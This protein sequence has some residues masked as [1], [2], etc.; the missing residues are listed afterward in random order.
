[1][2]AAEKGSDLQ[3]SGTTS[4]VEA[5]QTITVIFGGKSYTTTVAADNTWGLTIPAADVATLPD[6][7]ANV[8]ASV[9]NVAGNSAQAT[10]AYSVDATAPS[11]TINTIA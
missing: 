9:S 5:G 10:H 3:L 8:Q 4:D 6:G 2:N 7:A 1:I 11:V